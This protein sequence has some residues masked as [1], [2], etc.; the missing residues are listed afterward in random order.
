MMRV[1]R[2]EP[3]SANEFGYLVFSDVHLGSDIN[4]LAPRGRHRPSNLDDDLVALLDHYR[5]TASESASGLWHLV[6]AGDFIDFV[7]MLVA[8]TSDPNLDVSGDAGLG[9]AASMALRKLVR[10][11]DRHPLVFEALGRFVAAEHRLTFVV[12]NHDLELHWPVVQLALREAVVASVA[13]SPRARLIHHV[14]IEPIFFWAE[15]ALFVEHGHRYDPTCVGVAPLAPHSP[16][17]RD[18]MLPSLADVL[19]RLIVRRVEHIDEHGHENEDLAYYLKL[20]ARTGLHGIGN[21][22]RSFFHAIGIAVKTWWHLVRGGLRSLRRLHRQRLRRFAALRRIGWRK[23][24]AFDALAVKPSIASLHAI[25]STL[26]LDRI[27]LFGVTPFFVLAMFMLPASMLSR[28]AGAAALLLLARILYEKLVSLRE[29]D[30]AARMERRAHDVARLFPAAFVVMGHTHLPVER[31][32]SIDAVYINTGTWA[33][34]AD[35]HGL[36][37]PP[38]PRTHLVVEGRDGTHGELRRWVPG[39]GPARWRRDD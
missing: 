20:I 39:V 1:V 14:Q 13:P 4:E 36:V 5:V 37:T 22:A 19:L 9:S 7:G 3:R 18:R 35:D 15:G 24:R 28:A 27:A 25:F 12:G 34:E 17:A 2:S 31:P 16:L 10:A 38:A 30:A 32:L 8:D 11:V 26:L 23:L 29:L 6:I 21:L 33:E